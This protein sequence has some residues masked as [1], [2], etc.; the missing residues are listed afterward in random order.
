MDRGAQLAALERQKKMESRR[1]A[2]AVWETP[3]RGV[4]TEGQEALRRVRP[5]NVGQASRV[6]GVSPA[7]VGVLLIRIEEF[8]RSLRSGTPDQ[9]LRTS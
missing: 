7:D 3:L 1:I 2:G 6:R 4:S 9:S 8:A 5:E